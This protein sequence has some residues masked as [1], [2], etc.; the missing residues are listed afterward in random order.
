M[1]TNIRA[2]ARNPS[3]AVLDF[4]DLAADAAETA[5][6]EEV[7]ANEHRLLNK[8]DLALERIDKGS[9]GLCEK[10]DGRIPIAR[11][12]A[13]PAATRCLTCQIKKEQLEA[14]QRQPRRLVS[15]FD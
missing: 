14:A 3:N 7:D 13:K 11:L 12:R 1:L 4:A 10:C 15:A 2:E 9:Y 8:I 6:A 5:V